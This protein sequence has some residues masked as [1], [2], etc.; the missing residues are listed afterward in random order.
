MRNSGKQPVLNQSRLCDF[1]TCDLRLA[2]YVVVFA[3]A[4]VCVC[5]CLVYNGSKTGKGCSRGLI[6]C[7]GSYTR[8]PHGVPSHSAMHGAVATYNLCSYYICTEY[9]PGVHRECLDLCVC[10]CVC[11]WKRRGMLIPLYLSMASTYVHT[12]PT[13]VFNAGARG[14]ARNARTHTRRTPHAARTLFPS[15]TSTKKEERKKKEKKQ[16]TAVLHTYTVHCFLAPPTVPA[17]Y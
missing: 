3:L 6:G 8:A 14:A 12:V 5:V 9:S 11:V 15:R 2:T 7:P 16:F 17:S 1:A 4:R 10:V 13:F